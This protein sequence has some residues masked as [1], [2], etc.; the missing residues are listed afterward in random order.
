M[1]F[2]N[3]SVFCFC[4]FYTQMPVYKFVHLYI[5]IHTYFFLRMHVGVSCVYVFMPLAKPLK[6]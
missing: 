3:T 1:F 5:H 6:C 4:I 2:H